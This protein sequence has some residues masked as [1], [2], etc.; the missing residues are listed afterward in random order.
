M[1]KLIKKIR[2]NTILLANTGLRIGAGKD[3]VG[4]G[5]IDL[6]IVRNSWNNQPYIPGSSLKGKV[7]SLLDQKAGNAK[8]GSDE[9][10]PISDVFG[11]AVKGGSRIIFRD[12]P[13]TK[14]AAEYLKKAQNLDLPFTEAKTE[15]AID[16]STGTSLKNAL[17]TLERVPAGA[18]FD[19][20]IIINVFEDDPD[21]ENSWLLLKEGFELLNIDYLGGGGSRGHGKVTIAL[22]GPDFKKEM[23]TL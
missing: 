21:G 4:I 12:S 23:I 5:G 13:L 3:G 18:T 1:N 2:I 16:R 20:E 9:T 14:S 22:E 8:A 15:N 11:S 10:G 7:R 19:V 6:P 17:R